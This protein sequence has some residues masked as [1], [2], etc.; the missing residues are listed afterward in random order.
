MEECSMNIEPS[1]HAVSARWS[2]WHTQMHLN[3]DNGFWCSSFLRFLQN[4]DSTPKA[5]GRVSCHPMD[6]RQRKATAAESKVPALF[7]WKW[8]FKVFRYFHALR[9]FMVHLA[10]G[11]HPFDKD[12]FGGLCD[13]SNVAIWRIPGK[14]IA[15]TWW[16]LLP[17]LACLRN[18]LKMILIEIA[19]ICQPFSS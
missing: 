9:I 2:S 4:S 12:L 10:I 13:H 7:L 16:D 5:V 1:L 11:L 8:Y 14:G 15:S 19:V 18:G 3:A 6:S 17:Q